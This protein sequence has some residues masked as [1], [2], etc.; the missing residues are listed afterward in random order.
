MPDFDNANRGALFRNNQKRDD[1]DR[2]YAGTLNVD[3]V[4]YWLSGWVNTSKAG[5]KYLSLSVR[6][7]NAPAKSTESASED[8]NDALP[9]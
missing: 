9:F 2:D 7:K 4:E 6:P 3:G 8:L 5:R 1:K